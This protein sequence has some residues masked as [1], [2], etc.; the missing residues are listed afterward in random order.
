MLEPKQIQLSTRRDDRG[1][2]TEIFR[3]NWPDCS[4]SVQW[5]LIRSEANVLRGM[6]VHVSRIDYLV[7]LQG[8]VHVAMCD[9]RKPAVERRS[10]TIVELS[11]ENPS[12]LMIPTGVAH[13]FYFREA[14]SLVYGMTH[15]WDPVNDEF[16]C[17]WTDEALG[18]PW[19]AE[20]VAPLL[21]PRDEAAGSLDELLA[22]LRNLEHRSW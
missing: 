2:L 7:V 13:G 12:A 14:A 18:V 10:G 21:S 20:C 6:H 9:L 1:A 19:P 5:N 17:Q 15:Y 11:G 8:H 22:T 16:G 3:E 4:S